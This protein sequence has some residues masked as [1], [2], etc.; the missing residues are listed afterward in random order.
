M[1]CLEAKALTNTYQMIKVVRLV[2]GKWGFSLL[3]DAR[4]EFNKLDDGVYKLVKH[5]FKLKRANPENQQDA[6]KMYETMVNKA[7]YSKFLKCRK[8]EVAWDIEAV[9]KHLELNKH[10]NTQVFG[11]APLV[12]AKFGLTPTPKELFVHGLD[13][14]IEGIGLTPSENPKRLF[15]HGLDEGIEI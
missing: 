2:G 15:V 4:G 3:E 14:G 7:T 9:R 6:S 13:E 12:V 8:G 11:F 5:V 1:N 10:K